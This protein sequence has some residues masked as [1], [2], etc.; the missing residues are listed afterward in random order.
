MPALGDEELSLLILIAKFVRMQ[1]RHRCPV[2]VLRDLPNWRATLKELVGMQLA[3][4]KGDSVVLT[5]FGWALVCLHEPD[6]L[7]RGRKYK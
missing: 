4:S 5:H 7:K 6:V 2:S 3:V 1:G